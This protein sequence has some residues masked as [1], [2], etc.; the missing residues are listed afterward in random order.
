[1]VAVGEKDSGKTSWAK[2]FDG[3]IPE[4][5]RAAI[6]KEKVFGLSMVD[7]DTQIIT[8]DEWSEE[9]LAS[10]VAKIFLQGIFYKQSYLLTVLSNFYLHFHFNFAG[11]L[12][13]GDN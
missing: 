6:S 7:E 1:M 2:V 12:F 10:D 9:T 11:L 4:C 3:L 8:I 5:K 13:Q